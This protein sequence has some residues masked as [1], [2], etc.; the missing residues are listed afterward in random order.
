MLRIESLAVIGYADVVSGADLPA[1][2][3]PMFALQNDGN[4]VLLPPYQLTGDWLCGAHPVTRAEAED[5]AGA[6]EVTFLEE[7]MAARRDHQMYV[8]L[9]RRPHYLPRGEVKVELAKVAREYLV[10]AQAAWE[11]GRWEEA[12]RC[13]GIAFCADDRKYPALVIKGALRR[14]QG[15][16]AGEQLMASIASPWISSP[17][18]GALVDRYCQ[19]TPGVRPA[20]GRVP[21]MAGIA[22]QR[23]VYH[24]AA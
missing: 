2:V 13:A 3:P 9:E 12:E 5:L 21:V 24:A 1:I 19:S 4:Q 20:L 7:P 16:R 22:A 23:V 6:R 18:F 10:L 14:R 8:D 11:G 15:N 17:D